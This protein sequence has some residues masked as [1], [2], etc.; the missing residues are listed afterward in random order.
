MKYLLTLI[1][2]LGLV[3]CAGKGWI[4]EY[5]ANEAGE[6]VLKNA[7]HFE[8]KNIKCKTEK[9]AELETKNLEIPSVPFV[10]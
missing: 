10:R 1:L 7:T 3:G 5:E 4:F 6:L 9:G 8:G 2:C